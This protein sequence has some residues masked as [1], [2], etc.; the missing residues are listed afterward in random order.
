MSGLKR[1]RE[2]L[3]L[4]ATVALLWG[5]M[6]GCAQAAIYVLD[7]RHLERGATYLAAVAG[8]RVVAG[9]LGASLLVV[10]LGTLLAAALA[11]AARPIL[12]RGMGG[13][14]ERIVLLSAAWS[15]LYLIYR[16]F[17]A[18]LRQSYFGVTGVFS[19]YLPLAAVLIW[20]LQ[21]AVRRR[22]LEP[23]PAL[24]S[25]ALAG[26]AVLILAAGG[27][28]LWRWA[29]TPP[30]PSLVL[31]S[32]DTCRADRLSLTG[33]HRI[34]TPHL[35]RLAHE[36]VVFQQ[37][38]APDHYTLP[39]HMSLLTSAYPDVHRVYAT[40]S[41]DP[42]WTTLAEALLERGYDTA[43]F[44]AGVEWVHPRY[45]FDQGF[46]RFHYPTHLA[47]APRLN[48]N[49]IPWLWSHRGHPFFLFLHYFDLHSDAKG[50]PYGSGLGYEGLFRDPERIGRLQSQPR[51]SDAALFQRAIARPDTPFTREE[52][53]LLSDQ[54]D[55]GLVY[56]DR[57]LGELLRAIDLSGIDP[58][59]VVTSD[60]GEEFLEHGRIGH[61]DAYEP[62]LR[63]PL[64]IRFPQRR[65][66][67]RRVDQPVRLIDVAP[68]LLELAGVQPPVEFEGRSLLG[69]LRGQDHFP[70]YAYAK[71][72]WR[73]AVRSER[74]KLIYTPRSGRSELYDLR[75]DAAETLNL[76]PLYPGLT[77]ELKEAI[78]RFVS[79]SLQRHDLLLSGPA[80]S[81][82]I[83]LDEDSRQRLRALGYVP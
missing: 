8:L 52:A 53:E 78:L 83:Q 16:L 14:T 2:P 70:R 33:Y 35:D 18:L 64:M 55:S 77:Q 15:C 46:A 22:S 36:S 6:V 11:A 56:L 51:V 79:E 37:A 39:S 63:V 40:S 48:R 4:G 57:K 59:L 60:H 32:L 61:V 17:G 44:V 81:T 10:L 54:Y 38:I 31:V 75:S 21:R 25:A 65:F 71:G 82:E 67:G 5:L 13:W 45:G 19:P 26:L 12:P 42:R 47:F 73:Y 68:T 23:A 27:V 72:D 80:R 7:H 28:A 9:Y 30:G 76:A 66:A 20:L 50:L 29:R 3:A 41:L 34:T 1:F 49:A 58:V 43:A 74:W 69:L 24:V 62:V